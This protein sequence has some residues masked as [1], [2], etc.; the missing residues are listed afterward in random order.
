MR[1]L[2]GVFAL[3]AMGVFDAAPGAAQR[4]LSPGVQPF[5][6]INDPVVA[7]VGVRVIDGTGTP[8]QNGQTVLLRQNRIEAVGPSE[9]I[10]IPA[11]AHVLNLPGHTVI[12][13]YVMLHEHMF[14]GV[15]RSTYNQMEYSFPKLYLAG[16]ATTIRTGGSRD[17]YGDLNLKDAIDA[18]QVPGPRMH[19][20]G[21]YLNGP[22]LPI[23]F[24]NSLKNSE[25]ARNLVR[26]WA[27]EGVTSFKAYQ[28]ITRAELAAALEEAHARGIKVTGHLCSVTFRE[29]ADLGIDN[30]EHGFRPP[31]DFVKN[32]QP[33]VCPD[34]AIRERSLLALDVN[35]PEARSLIK[36]L[37]DKGVAVTSTLIVTEARAPGRPP[38]RPAVLD[39]MAPPIRDQYLRTWASIQEQG[40]RENAELLVREMELGKAFS[41]A[42]G[43]LVAGTDP[44]SYGGVIAGF[45][46][47]REIELL[48]ESGFS[49]EQ[50]IRIATL[51]GATYLGIAH[52]LGTVEA[53]KL[54]DLVVLEGDPT[55]DI[56]AV[57]NVR[58]VF[59]DGIGYDPA[60]L[61][62]AVQGLV[63]FH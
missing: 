15:G 3:L 4:A 27:D 56:T 30:L 40:N 21:P 12:P 2:A 51:N 58:L 37:V 8:G 5:V 44:T 62:Q 39:V 17:P 14:Y 20:T 6:E 22:G 45:A 63:G 35:G 41:D 53:G 19:V 7:L 23:L 36:H 42:G 48:H 34:A 55:S 47:Q 43:L 10:S 57:R 46:N 16:G 50:A 9:R 13:G 1:A 26:Y 60:R 38:A 18:G 32:K 61:I 52:E 33:D 11:E 49:P 29:A 25:E 54:A 31:T 24:V 28:Q 59:K